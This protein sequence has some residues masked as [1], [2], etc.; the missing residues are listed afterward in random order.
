[1]NLEELEDL[2][3][4]DIYSTKF[5]SSTTVNFLKEMKS[6]KMKNEERMT[7]FEKE[8]HSKLS[9][10]EKKNITNNRKQNH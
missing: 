9:E 2:F 5:N 6:E 4:N 1:M 7:N 3:Q 8:I 10:I